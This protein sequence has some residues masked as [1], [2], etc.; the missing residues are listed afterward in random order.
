[1][2]VLGK[3]A[4]FE[5]IAVHLHPF[6]VIFQT[7][8]ALLP[9][10]CTQL[11]IIIT[12]LLKHIVK[13]SVLDD[14]HTVTQ[15]LKIKYEDPEHCV[16]PAKVDIGYVAENQLKQLGQKKKLSDVRV[17]AFREECMA[18]MKA[19]IAKTPIAH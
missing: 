13:S 15:L 4:S 10:V 9:F 5:A 11:H 7:D 12:G 18:F 2:L 6:L 17:F 14:A 19:I 8:N 16:R 1:M 3:M